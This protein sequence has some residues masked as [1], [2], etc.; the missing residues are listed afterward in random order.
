MVFTPDR[1]LGEAPLTVK[2]DAGEYV[3]A[4]R[5]YG[6]MEGFDGACVRKTM[7]DQ[8]TGGVRYTYHLMS[9]RKREG[10]YQLYVANF[11]PAAPE[12][13]KAAKPS[14]TSGVFRFDTAALVAD[15]ASATNV[16]EEQRQAM[17]E[18][19]NRNGVAFYSA[20]GV[21]CLVKL[22]LFGAK[23][24]IDEWPVE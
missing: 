18:R 5:T 3:L 24:H 21:Q 23:Y 22:T 2:L 14:S 10:E 7:A 1:L 17:A 15:L 11:K 8:I 4:V 20:T 6:R 9:L 13:S 16:P 19:L 12:A